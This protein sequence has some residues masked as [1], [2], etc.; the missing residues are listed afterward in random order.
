M[1]FVHKD[2][3]QKGRAGIYGASSDGKPFD[4]FSWQRGNQDRKAAWEA[5][6]PWKNYPS[7]SS[8]TSDSGGAGLVGLIVLGVIGYAVFGGDNKTTTTAPNTTPNYQATVPSNSSHQ[9]TTFAATVAAQPTTS[10]VAVRCQLATAYVA[11]D[12]RKWDG[13]TTI[14]LRQGSVI[15]NAVPYIQ[16]SDNRFFKGRLGKSTVFVRQ[17]DIEGVN[18]VGQ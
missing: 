5:S 15:I 8:D 14:Q 3:Y 12:G 11:P 17:S 16:A 6:N 7:S 2:S 10:A 1:V 18:C 4:F 9:A 13:R